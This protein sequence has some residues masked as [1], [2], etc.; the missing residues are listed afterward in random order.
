M[1]GGTS[2]LATGKHADIGIR[3][4]NAAMHKGKAT[5]AILVRF[6]N[7]RINANELQCHSN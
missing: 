6:E 4:I 1:L 7:G 3:G 5:S 2:F